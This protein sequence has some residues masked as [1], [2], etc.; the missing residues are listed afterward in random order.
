[1]PEEEEEEDSLW[2]AMAKKIEK[3][4]IA[5]QVVITKRLSLI[6]YIQ[7]WMPRCII[8][9]RIQKMRNFLATSLQNIP[10]I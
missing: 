3:F 6:N 5:E 7:K 10:K 9:K 1:L 2:K 4:V 8:M